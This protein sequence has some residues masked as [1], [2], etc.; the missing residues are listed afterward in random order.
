MQLVRCHADTGAECDNGKRL[1]GNGGNVGETY[2]RNGLHAILCTSVGQVDCLILIITVTILAQNPIQRSI[3]ER[4]L[5]EM[6]GMVHGPSVPLI[7][8]VVTFQGWGLGAICW[9][10]LLSKQMRREGLWCKAWLVGSLWLWSL[11][12]IPCYRNGIKRQAEGTYRSREVT[13]RSREAVLL[14]KTL[15]IRS[16][17]EQD[18]LKWKCIPLAVRKGWVC[19]LTL[20]SCYLMLRYQIVFLRSFVNV[21]SVCSFRSLLHCD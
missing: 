20:G 2:W 3:F 4:K 10:S 6:R 15:C 13:C 1:D 18:F 19:K 12:I 11:C 7:M 16:S 8:K 21:P 17:T 9:K 14:I 5:L